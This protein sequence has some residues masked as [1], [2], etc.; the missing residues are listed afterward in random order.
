MNRKHAPQAPI[1]TVLGPLR[2]D[3]ALAALEAGVQVQRVDAYCWSVSSSAASRQGYHV[4]RTADDLGYACTCQAA[5]NDL[6]C[7]HAAL[8]MMVEATGAVEAIRPPVPGR[9]Y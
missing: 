1:A 8:V 7:R 5:A 6:E 3:L 2:A 9:G 4:T